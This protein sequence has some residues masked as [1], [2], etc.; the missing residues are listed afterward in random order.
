MDTWNVYKETDN[1]ILHR[2]VRIINQNMLPVKKLSMEEASI[3]LGKKDLQSAKTFLYNY[4]RE[5]SGWFI[6]YEEAEQ[7]CVKLMKV[8]KD[9]LLAY[10]KEK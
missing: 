6:R 7:R 10:G 2:V 1:D 9:F 4:R 3:I 8:Y 5:S